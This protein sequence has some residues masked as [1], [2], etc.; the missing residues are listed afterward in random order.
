MV[1]GCGLLEQR[2]QTFPL[3]FVYFPDLL[4]KIHEKYAKPFLSGVKHSC[5]G[6]EPPLRL[7]PGSATVSFDGRSFRRWLLPP[8]W[9]PGFRIL[10]MLLGI[11]PHSPRCGLVDSHVVVFFRKTVPELPPLPSPGT[12]KERRPRSGLGFRMKF[13]APGHL[14]RS[15]QGALVPEH[16]RPSP[17]CQKQGL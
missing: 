11:R 8:T 14:A 4:E 16:Q 15:G 2:A 5:V 7:E 1:G 3:H 9:T 12:A 13:W 10:G 6:P 17:L